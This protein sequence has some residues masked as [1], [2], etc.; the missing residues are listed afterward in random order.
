[1]NCLSAGT[2]FN[3]ARTSL[4]RIASIAAASA[5]A[6][7]GRSEGSFASRHI[8]SA[9]AVGETLS[10]SGGGVSFTCAKAIAICDSPVNGRCP[11]SA[12]YPIIPSDYISDEGV[13]V[14]PVACSG[15]KYWAV[16][17]T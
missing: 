10:G 14:C 12:S 15:A 16:P 8:I 5:V 7:A 13:A 4:R 6:L 17:I 9:R 2:A 11:A 1:M 3:A